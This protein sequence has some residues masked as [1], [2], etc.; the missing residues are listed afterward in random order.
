MSIL[1]ATWH[2]VDPESLVHDVTWS[3]RVHHDYQGH[4]P[5]DP[6]Y[7]SSSTEGIKADIRLYDGDK[8]FLSV[9]GCNGAGECLL[10]EEVRLVPLLSAIGGG[11]G[12]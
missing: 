11:L 9:L 6:V 7:V 1:R 12:L 8:Y 5:V 2:F 10:D 3:V 4:Q